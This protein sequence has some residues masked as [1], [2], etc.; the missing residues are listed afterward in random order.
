[1]IDKV[2]IA[3]GDTP[4]MAAF[5]AAVFGA[6]L[7]PLE[8]MGTTI[9]VGALGGVE[10]LLCPKIVAG[11]TA[12]ENTIQLRIVVAD[13]PGAVAAAQQHGGCS[14]GDVFV[15]EG[16]AM[17][18]IRDPDGNSIEVVGPVQGASSA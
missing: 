14:L 2:T 12:R 5:Y 6:E 17:G 9:W 7:S 18:A 8:A 10:L 11:I 3:T 4:K 13:V 1:M 15:H 16:R